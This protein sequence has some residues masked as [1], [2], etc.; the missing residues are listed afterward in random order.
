MPARMEFIV[1]DNASPKGDGEALQN[2]F[3]D[4]PRTHVICL[5]NNLGFGG[6]YAEG[7]KFARGKFLG[8]LN[9]DVRVKPECLEIL[10]SVFETQK[11]VGIIAPSLKNPDGSLQIN[12]RKFPTPW[13]L[14]VRRFFPASKQ[15][16]DHDSAWYEGKNPVA[17]DWLQGS[18]LLLERTFF[19]NKL[20][21]FDRRFF[22]FLEDTD[23]CRR[24]WEAGKRVLIVPQA[25]AV[26]GEERLSGGNVWRAI[27]KRTFWIHVCSGLK[28]FWKYKF[29]KSPKT[30]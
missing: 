30:F 15:I 25:E 28:Y 26:H 10:A 4:K 14:F 24:T 29:K 1:V 23:L 18:F 20:G 17:V 12:A 11:N 7:V 13:T 27:W 6:G 8:I 5:E 19:V 21:G 22:L 3:R 16:G 9:P 2:F